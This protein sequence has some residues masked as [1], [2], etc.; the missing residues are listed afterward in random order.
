ME[1]SVVDYYAILGLDPGASEESIKV[2]YRRLAREHHPDGKV[3]ST[4]SERE[5]LS[6]HMAQLNGAYAVLSDAK[7]RREYDQKLKIQGSLQSGSTV[8]R[9][10]NPVSKPKSNE[11]AQLP[12]EYDDVDLVVAR[13]LSRQ[14]R[15]NLLARHKGISW[16]EKDLE[17][18]DW[19]LEG[20]SWSSH[21]C[22]AGLGFGALNLASAKMFTTYSKS[23]IE[24]NARSI[25]KSHFLFLLPF[26]RLNEWEFVSAEF[27]RFFSAESHTKFS[28]VPVEIAL[29]DARQGRTTRFGSQSR[30]K[31][32]EELLQCAS[33]T[34]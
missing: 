12:H 34:S 2:V 1:Y 25:R 32:L 17:G 11:R 9:A 7:L 24:R 10:T 8:S 3:D 20:S 16:I 22:V 31:R 28:K 33:A 13:E 27:N 18:F 5:R 14:I 26:Q 15:A 4:E 21:F 30:E 6:A 29:L 23:I 19:G